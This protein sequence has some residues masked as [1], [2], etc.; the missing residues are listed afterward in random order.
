MVPHGAI[1]MKL[2]EFLGL[3]PGEAQSVVVMGVPDTAK[4]EMLVVLTTLEISPAEVRAKLSAAGLPNLWIP[5]SVLR[6]PAIPMLG[7]G[8]LDLAACRRLAMEAGRG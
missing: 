3:D 8:K 1:E 4:G 6:V 7:S 2:S 5:R